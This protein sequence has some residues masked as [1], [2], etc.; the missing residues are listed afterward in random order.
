MSENYIHP[1][2]DAILMPLEVILHPL[3]EDR[4]ISPSC[5]SAN[6][7]CLVMKLLSVM[8]GPAVVI[9]CY[10]ALQGGVYVVS[11]VTHGC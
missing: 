4:R 2:L 5:N 9:V 8:V 10:K 7:H 6:D 3:W 11:K 1:Y